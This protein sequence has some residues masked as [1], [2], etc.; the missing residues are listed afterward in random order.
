MTPPDLDEAVRLAREVMDDQ[1]QR[2]QAK[3]PTYSPYCLRCSGLVRLKKIERDL[4]QCTRC[5]VV[6]DDRIARALLAL[7]PV[8]RAAQEWRD[9]PHK[10]GCAANAG[11]D[12]GCE[13]CVA[14]AKLVG[15]VLDSRIATARRGGG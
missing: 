1:V 4:W 2:N 12:A 7:E 3:D 11:W 15:A 10:Q 13:R 8:W 6:R 9:A 14:G 5:D